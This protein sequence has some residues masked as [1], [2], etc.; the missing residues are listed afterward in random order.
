[1]KILQEFK[2][3]T[4]SFEINGENH[5]AEKLLMNFNI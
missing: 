5:K 2:T 1:M 3:T 4:K